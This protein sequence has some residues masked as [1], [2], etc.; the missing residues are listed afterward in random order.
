MCCMFFVLKKRNIIT[1]FSILLTII[2]LITTFGLSATESA[3]VL[4]NE[5][6]VTRVRT[7]D[8]KV[9]LSVNVY[10]NTDIDAVLTALGDAKATF[11]IS[12]EFEFLHGDKVRQL[13]SDGHTVGILEVKLTDNTD[14][15]INDRMAERIEK[16]S[17]LTGKNC[18][19]VRFNSDAFDRKC[20]NAVS[21]LAL[22]T[23]QWSTD[24]T[25]EKVQSG[26]II[27]ITGESEIKDFIKKITDDGFKTTTVDGLIFKN[28]NSIIKLL[29]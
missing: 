7:K 27:L 18:Q 11:F 29:E 5:M 28:N 24:D 21:A 23:V 1:A 10:E 15:E 25:T 3:T 19:L 2:F 20:I 8:N 16:L 22:H 9:A 13:I 17:F 26:D 6:P 12:E 4:V 14:N